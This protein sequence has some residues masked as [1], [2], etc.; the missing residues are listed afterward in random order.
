MT[1]GLAGSHKPLLKNK[2]DETGSY[3]PL[4]TGHYA[5]NHTCLE[6]LLILAGIIV[7]PVMLLQNI[8]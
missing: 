7:Y 3:L 2:S 8:S 5:D 4:S 1:L 6:I